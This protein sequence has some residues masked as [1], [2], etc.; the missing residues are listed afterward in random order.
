MGRN[1]LLA[2]GALDILAALIH[3]AAIVGGPS[4][5]RVL[6]AGE[7]FARAAARGRIEPHLYTTGIAAV[8]LVWAAYAFSG[9]EMIGRLPLLRPALIAIAAIYLVRAAVFPAMMAMAPGRWSLTFMLTTSGIVVVMG[10]LHA[11]GLWRS[12]DVLTPR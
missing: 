4:W 7:G 12:W 2:A 11:I 6:G 8:L 1:L 5:Y 3:L 9:A 10:L